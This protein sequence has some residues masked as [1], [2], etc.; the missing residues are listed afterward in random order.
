[1]S[2]E[3]WRWVPGYEGAYEVS[4]HGRVR[5][6]R[7]WTRG[8][9]PRYLKPQPHVKYGHRKVMLWSQGAYDNWYVHR[10][11]LAAFVGPMP[12]GQITRHLDGDPS[13]NHLNNLAYG[14]PAENVADAI[15]HGTVA[16]GSKSHC[17]WGHLY[18]TEN[19]RV[20]PQ[21]WHVCR[22]CERARKRNRRKKE[23]ANAAT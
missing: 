15:R 11:V 21:G 3:T 4:D 10:L 5:S 14:T 8:P 19:T 7:K 1:M 12:E 13:N 22:K 9:A 20:T 17:K 18:D 2:E 6:W 23:R 16:K